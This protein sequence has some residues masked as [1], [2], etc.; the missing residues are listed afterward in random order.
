MFDPLISLQSI[1]SYRRSALH[2]LSYNS[3]MHPPDNRMNASSFNVPSSWPNPRNIHTYIGIYIYV[4]YV[5]IY[6]CVR[7]IHAW[8]T[9]WRF[10]SIQANASYVVSANFVPPIARW[11]E[12]R[13]W[14][15]ETPPLRIFP[16]I[17]VGFPGLPILQ[18]SEI[19]IVTH[20][21]DRHCNS[22]V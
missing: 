1:I 7:I 13:S 18:S 14:N 21:R 11:N 19:E 6:M 3:Q 5:Y 2:H 4:L 15:S 20:I 16:G 10:I 22:S 9:T 17:P 8:C 12:T